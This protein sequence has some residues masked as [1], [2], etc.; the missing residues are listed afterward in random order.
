MKLPRYVPVL[1]AAAVLLLLGS[2]GGAVAG[3][4][5]TSKQIKDN[6]ITTKDIKNKTLTTQDLSSKTVKSLK[7]KNGKD[8]ASAWDVIPSGNTVSGYFYDTGTTGAAL[9]GQV[10]N[11]NLPG[12]APAAPTSYAFAP[13]SLT[14]TSDEDPTCTGTLA[15]PTAPPG[16]VCV[17]LDGI[18]GLTSARV[19]PWDAAEVGDRTFYLSFSEP[20]ADTAYYYYGAWAYTAP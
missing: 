4:L 6:T 9:S 11:I 7:G 14:E 16:K 20:A 3:S 13:D 2:T 19:Y 8:G 12:V 18:G 1:A 5:I 15:E 10:E 17:Y